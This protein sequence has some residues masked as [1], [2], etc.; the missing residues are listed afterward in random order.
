MMRPSRVTCNIYLRN[1]PDM[2][3]ILFSFPFIR[4]NTPSHSFIFFLC[5][6]YARVLWLLF[7]W[8]T[9]TKRYIFSHV[10]NRN[11]NKSINQTYSAT[12]YIAW[13]KTVFK[14]N[15]KVLKPQNFS[16]LANILYKT[17]F[18]EGIQFIILFCHLGE[19]F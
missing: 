17:V 5:T 1:S 11:V 19:K 8:K 2:T 10:S 9:Y 16:K 7:N 12:D 18:I 4:Q 3:N 13:G 14:S 15:V 6:S